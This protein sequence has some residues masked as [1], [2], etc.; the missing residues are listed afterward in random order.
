M[1][2]PPS[3]TNKQN[4]HFLAHS[5]NN[6]NNQNLTAFSCTPRDEVAKNPKD[7]MKHTTIFNHLPPQTQ[8]INN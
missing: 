8:S 1:N 2:T 6:N 4:K 7:D 5:I 3:N